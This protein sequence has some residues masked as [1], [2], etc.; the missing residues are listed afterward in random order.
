MQR[1]ERDKKMPFAVAD[2][3]QRGK[4][5]MSKTERLAFFRS[6]FLSARSFSVMGQAKLMAQGDKAREP[7]CHGIRM[8][9]LYNERENIKE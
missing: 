6:P 8:R 3:L 4:N 9:H 7:Q 1:R 2:L 5:P